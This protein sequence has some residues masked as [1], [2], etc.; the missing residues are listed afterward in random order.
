MR[1]MQLPFALQRLSPVRRTVLVAAG[2]ALLGLLLT[3]LPVPAPLRT[4]GLL[5]RGGAAI[6]LVLLWL[7]LNRPPQIAPTGRVIVGVAPFAEV[8][9]HAILPPQRSLLQR[10]RPRPRWEPVVDEDGDTLLTTPEGGLEWADFLLYQ[11]QKTLSGVPDV[12]LVALPFVADAAAAQSAGRGLGAHLVLWGRTR[13]VA[14]PVRWGPRLTVVQRLEPLIPASDLRLCGIETVE[15]PTQRLRTWRDRYV[16]LQHTQAL[17]L[18]MVFYAYG[19]DEEAL[20]EFAAV[21]VALSENEADDPARNVAHLLSGNLYT[22]SERWDAA[23]TAYA[24]VTAASPLHAAAQVNLGIVA[25]LRGDTVRALDQLALAVQTVPDLA[26]AHHNLAVLQQRV[27]RAAEAETHYRAAMT[28]DPLLSAAYRGFAAVAQQRRDVATALEALGQAARQQPNDAEVRRDLAALLLDQGRLT[29]A[30]V[31]VDAAVRLDPNHAT[32]QYLL[33]LSYQQ[34]GND[35]LATEALEQAIRLQPNFADAHAALGQLYKQ[36]GDDT[37]FTV[38]PSMRTP[39]SADARAHLELGESYFRQNRLAEAEREFRA[40]VEQAPNLAVAQLQLGRVL[41]KQGHAEAALAALKLALE[42]DQM[43]LPAYHELADIRREAGDW[44][45]AAQ[46]LEHTARIAP[47]D[48]QTAYMLGNVRAAHARAGGGRTALEAALAAYRRAIALKPDYAAAHYNL[49]VATLSDGD[50]ASAVDSLGA[51]T[52][53][54]PQDGEAWRLLGSVYNDLR[55]RPQALEALGRAAALRPQHIPT[56]L[57]LAQLQRSEQQWEPAIATLRQLIRSD[58]ANTRALHDLAHT[59]T[60]AGQHDRAS[61]LWLR[62]KEQQPE[63]AEPYFNLGLAYHAAGRKEAAI[64]SLDNGLAH[65]IRDLPLLLQA[66]QT[67]TVLGRPDRA[68]AA[69]QHALRSHRREPQLYYALGQSYTAWGQ[70]DRANEA[71]RMYAETR[72]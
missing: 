20:N 51:A 25:A 48:A 50:V 29:D 34:R 2:L 45:R 69:L 26:L 54:D 72:S 47:T 40:A 33:G 38:S 6:A 21:Q 66:A 65:E 3:Y 58:P 22:V 4:L 63:Q 1:R 16:G 27:G 61:A 9:P 36:Q 32:T 24:A 53:L 62:I 49:A 15:L 59:Y 23:T 56:L 42:D 39:V 44:E 11:L 64:E 8:V 57:Q 17:V 30:Q 7:R 41:R 43:L 68:V 46:T 28:L 5:L 37:L 14:V 35:A 71:Y 60:A 13:R 18:G 10:L 67:L 52:R 55:R 19:A 31:H 12:T 70:P